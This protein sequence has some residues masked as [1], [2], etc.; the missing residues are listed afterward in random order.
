LEKKTGANI[1]SMF[2]D[3]TNYWKFNMRG[4]HIEFIIIA[5]GF[6]T[7]RT[8][9]A[10][11][12]WIL[13]I[14]EAKPT[15]FTQWIAEHCPANQGIK[16]KLSGGIVQTQFVFQTSYGEN[17]FFNAEVSVLGED[18]IANQRSMG[19]KINSFEDLLK[20][21][22]LPDDDREVPN[23]LKIKNRQFDDVDVSHNTVDC[24]I[25]LT[26]PEFNELVSLADNGLLFTWLSTLSEREMERFYRYCD[27]VVQLAEGH[28]GPGARAQFESAMDGVDI[29]K[30]PDE[31]RARA[32][33]ELPLMINH[34]K[35]IYHK[36]LAFQTFTKQDNFDGYYDD[37]HTDGW[38]IGYGMY[39]GLLVKIIWGE[40]KYIPDHFE[41][42]LDKFKTFYDEENEEHK[43]FF[44][45]L[46]GR[47]GMLIATLNRLVVMT[48][49]RNTSLNWFTGK[50]VEYD[51]V[52]SLEI[53]IS[54]SKLLT[55]DQKLINFL[56][57][58]FLGIC[59][60]NEDNYLSSLICVV[61]T[62][63]EWYPL[64][65]EACEYAMVEMMKSVAIKEVNVENANSFIDFFGEL[66]RLYAVLSYDHIYELKELIC[67]TLAN[68]KPLDNKVFEQEGVK[69]KLILLNYLVDME[70]LYYESGPSETTSEKVIYKSSVGSLAEVSAVELELKSKGFVKSA[71]GQD[72]KDIPSGE[73]VIVSLA[74]VRPRRNGE[75]QYRIGWAGSREM[76]A[77]NLERE[78]K[79]A[80]KEKL[81]QLYVLPLAEYIKLYN[82][83]ESRQDLEKAGLWNHSVIIDQS[84]N[85][86]ASVIKNKQ[87][88]YIGWDEST[89]TPD[90]FDMSQEIPVWFE[91]VNGEFLSVGIPTHLLKLKRLDHE[92]LRVAPEKLY[93]LIGYDTYDYSNYF[94]ADFGSFSEA[95]KGLKLEL[96][97]L[98]RANSST[99]FLYN[100]QGDCL[101]KG[102]IEDGVETM[103]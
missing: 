66:P 91:K 51:L 44:V 60:E 63:F 19:G 41:Q 8:L 83:F 47:F 80:E 33:L 65:R 73:Y 74:N 94:I 79:Q 102:S 50:M 68:E 25:E 85:R 103:Q 3:G 35:N 49:E 2:G 16:R 7:T 54:Q 46:C 36:T 45:H 42:V 76:V 15:V 72:Q 70:D 40:M 99:L 32:T 34:A 17:D 4:S 6:N 78:R 18:S 28:D 86:Y 67:H 96:Q 87:A 90:I 10:E 38:E 93:R 61:E 71:E 26:S 52:G 29:E 5:N 81:D 101:M 27:E 62:L 20:R 30:I 21:G 14:R 13:R 57:T 92:Q 43:R 88:G 23:W 31:H 55:T 24:L 69:N 84:W 48:Q 98:S 75:V 11:H 58:T 1:F 22:N 82:T 12:K 89:I 56:T 53:S 64:N 100:D 39:E 9:K 95:E 37:C 97:S 77:L 59:D